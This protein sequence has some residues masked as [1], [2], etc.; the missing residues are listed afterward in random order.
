MR[1]RPI[2]SGLALPMLMLAAPPAAA[3]I[4]PEL[5]AFDE[6]LPGSLINDPRDI[7]WPTQ[8]SALDVKGV[9]NADIPG[10]GAAR[11]Y[12]VKTKGPELWSSQTHVPLLAPIERGDTV[13]VGFYART[14]SADT[15][16]GKGL[17]GVRVQENAPPYGGFGEKTLFIGSDWEW[18]EV[19]GSANLPIRQ[20][21][22]TI[23]FQFGAAKQT[24]EIGQT[25]VVK[26]ATSILGT[27]KPAEEKPAATDEPLIPEPLAG[28]GTLLNKPDLRNWQ[29]SA[30]VGTIENRDEPGIWLGHATRFS[31]TELGQNDWDLVAGI[32][33]EQ[34]IGAGDKLLI[35]IAAKTV[36]AETPDGNGL[37]AMRIQDNAPPYDGF[38]ENIFN[39]GQK[40]QLIRIN[41][42]APRDIP[43]GTAQVALHFAA[44][45]QS[46]DVGPVY[47][48][49]TE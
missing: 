4:P 36:S 39:I 22:A 28:A 19:T 45:V 49:K 32:P 3:Q 6:Q 16:D 12:E 13:T 10:G 21:D 27:Q 42:V 2:L 37:V 33:I 35:A 8:G 31:L 46:I 25:I 30:V 20:K 24:I 1:A 48:F 11:R 34:D 15:A 18:Y 47:V 29:N 43:A 5:Q 9:Q 17:L 40:W 26:G 44:E 14:V 38:A 7:V 41:T 23:A